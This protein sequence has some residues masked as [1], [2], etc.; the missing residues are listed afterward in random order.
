MEY[1]TSRKSLAFPEY[2]RNVQMLIDYAVNLTDPI[3]KE[4][5]V[6]AI[7]SIMG[8]LNPQLRDN[9]PDFKHILWDHLAIMSDFKLTQFSPYPIPNKE[10]LYSK[11]SP[12]FRYEKDM[13]YPIFG[14]IIEGLMNKCKTIDDPVRK[15]EMIKTITNHMKKSYVLW[16]KENINDEVIF[17]VLKEI[18]EGELEVRDEGLKLID[19][20]DFMKSK[21]RQNAQNNQNN[22]SNRN[23]RNNSSNQ[24][25]YNSN[26]RYYTNNYHK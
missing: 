7:I 14:R 6:K 3:D 25:G 24:Q 17:K 19:G 15:N 13:K 16:N 22:F 8:N 10:N 1:N 11:P 20:R 21:S 9:H 26:R 2:G 12:V 23:G 4:K 5:S 18:S